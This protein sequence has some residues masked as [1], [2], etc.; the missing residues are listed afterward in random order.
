LKAVQ[1]PQQIE[2]VNFELMT[3]L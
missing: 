1:N 3:I 2:Q